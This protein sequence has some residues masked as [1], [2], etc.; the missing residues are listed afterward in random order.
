[1]EVFKNF[2][3]AAINFSLDRKADEKLTEFIEKYQDHWRYLIAQLYAFR[4]EKE[5]AFKWPES[6]YDYRG[7]WLWWIKND[8]WLKK[9]PG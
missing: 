8:R 2:G 5:E 3:L 4:N 1:M 9:Y 6:A 7:R